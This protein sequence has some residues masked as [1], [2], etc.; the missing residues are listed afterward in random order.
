MKP[1]GAPK[2]SA[3]AFNLFDHIDEEIEETVGGEF[4]VDNF[5]DTGLE[6][7]LETPQVPPPVV[8]TPRPAIPAP[9]PAAEGENGAAKA[10]IKVSQISTKVE[11]KSD[12][13]LKREEERQRAQA[14]SE[15]SL[16][17]MRLLAFEK[18]CSIPKSFKLADI[19]RMLKDLDPQIIANFV[20][21]VDNDFIIKYDNEKEQVV[22]SEISGPEMEI[23]S[24]QFEKW[25]R[26]G[27]L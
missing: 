20:V 3:A 27:R 23:L 18:A 14:A 4:D 19:S 15:S 22:I 13:D 24:R 16:V 2:P 25:L 6:L 5:L 11:K 21:A 17:Y 12:A 10:A 9:A 26:F 8:P 1:V 7:N